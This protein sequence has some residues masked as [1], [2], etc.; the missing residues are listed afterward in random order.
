MWSYSSR[1]YARRHGIPTIGIPESGTSADRDSVEWMWTMQG[2]DGDGCERKYRIQA[3]SHSEVEA[4][5]SCCVATSETKNSN[6]RPRVMV[7]QQMADLTTRA[8][9]EEVAHSQSDCGPVLLLEGIE[10]EDE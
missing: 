10:E 4:D 7:L 8:M 1:E 9:S 2:D 3:E 6:D 5:E